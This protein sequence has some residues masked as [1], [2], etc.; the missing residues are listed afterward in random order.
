MFLTKKEKR[1]KRNKDSGNSKK[2]IKKKES[3]TKILGLKVKWTKA[4]KER[5]KYDGLIAC[6]V[7]R[8][9][10]GSHLQPSQ[11]SKYPNTGQPMQLIYI[12]KW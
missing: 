6:H 11:F 9:I 7:V 8:E 10:S 2:F 1:K 4:E 5:N 3:W 12:F